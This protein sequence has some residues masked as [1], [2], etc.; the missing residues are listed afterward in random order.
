[1]PPIL[2]ASLIAAEGGEHW[3]ILCEHQTGPLKQLINAVLPQMKRHD[4]K[5]YVKADTSVLHFLVEHE[6]MYM[7][8]TDEGQGLRIPFGYLDKINKAFKAKYGGSGY[9]DV[10]DLSP[11]K[12]KAFAKELGNIMVQC[13]DQDTM[14]LVDAEVEGIKQCMVQNIEDALKRGENVEDL[15]A[16][17]EDLET[18]GQGF[19]TGA[20]KL[21][22]E[23]FWRNIKFAIAAVLLLAVL[24]TVIVLIACQGPC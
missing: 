19:K 11:A 15:C 23:M 8:I 3:S 14:N 6:I 4:Q 10:S 17:A 21:K 9:P 18:E 1:M 13:N 20:R 24:I 12:C 5:N 16:K 22:N 7:V 2:K